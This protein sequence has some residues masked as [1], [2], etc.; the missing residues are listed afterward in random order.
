MAVTLASI[1]TAKVI[2][3]STEKWVIEASSIELLR[4]VFFS[5]FLSETRIRPFT[6]N[7]GIDCVTK[8]V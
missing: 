6:K 5:G 1:S 8:E 2:Y 3:N 7:L 4:S